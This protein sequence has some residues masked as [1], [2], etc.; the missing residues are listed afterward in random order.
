MYFRG[1]REKIPA[2]E[3][4]IKCLPRSFVLCIKLNRLLTKKCAFDQVAGNQD[5]HKTVRNFSFLEV[6]SFP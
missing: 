3:G 6:V 4:L 1:T 5:K 2:W